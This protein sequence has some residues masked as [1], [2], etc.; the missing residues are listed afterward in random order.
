MKGAGGRAS[1]L[2]THEERQV[3]ARSGKLTTHSHKSINKD[4]IKSFCPTEAS[5]YYTVRRV[6]VV[7]CND[8]EARGIESDIV[9]VFTSP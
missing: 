9:E 7:N 2:V 3:V 4:L 1:G 8:K 6:S 5:C